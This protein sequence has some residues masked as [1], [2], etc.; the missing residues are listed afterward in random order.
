MR[1]YIDRLNRENNER[2]LVIAFENELPNVEVRYSFENYFLGELTLRK[3]VKDGFVER[4]YLLTDYGCDATNHSANLD[5]RSALEFSDIKV[6]KIYI[7]FM[8]KTFPDY[9]ENYSK[10][11]NS[12]ALENL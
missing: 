5:G 8:S 11:I 7:S 12:Q 6:K 2:K 3:K 4:V 9:K 10:K 1:S